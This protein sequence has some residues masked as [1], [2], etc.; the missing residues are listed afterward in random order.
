MNIHL[1]T[2]L[3]VSLI[4]L[5]SGCHGGGEQAQYCNDACVERFL[6]SR[7]ES[8]KKAAKHLRT[9]LSWRDTVGAGTTLSFHSSRSIFAESSRLG[10]SLLLLP[11][12]NLW[13]LGRVGS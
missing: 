8:V 4:S 7:G 9:V 5:L 12:R 6:R 2:S 10:P 3:F 1:Y 13:W 11:L